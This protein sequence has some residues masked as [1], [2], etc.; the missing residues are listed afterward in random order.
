MRDSPPRHFGALIGGHMTYPQVAARFEP[1]HREN[2]AN[3]ANIHRVRHYRG[4]GAIA[5][6]LTLVVALLAFAQVASEV[7]SVPSREDSPSNATLYT[8][9]TCCNVQPPLSQSATIEPRV[10]SLGRAYGKAYS[11]KTSIAQQL[12]SRSSFQGLV[13]PLEGLPW[14]LGSCPGPP[15][16]DS[17]PT[18][19]GQL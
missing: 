5:D 13:T 9:W 2:I 6:F 7:P 8:C 3:S 18:I 11:L 16:S 17:Q 15:G 12:P 19:K 1:Q 14:Q 4:V 10:E